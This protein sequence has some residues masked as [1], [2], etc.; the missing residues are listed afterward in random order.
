MN[1]N[2][3]FSIKYKLNPR[4][5]Q[6]TVQHEQLGFIPEIQGCFN[7]N[8]S[9]KVIHYINRLEN[10]QHLIIQLDKEKAFNNNVTSLYNKSIKETRDM[11]VIAQFNKDDV[12]Q[13]NTNIILNGEKLKAFQLK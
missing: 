9:I 3:N 4:T 13:A 7:I 10:R 5:H 6:N 8:K 11:K 12:L 1:I 2:E